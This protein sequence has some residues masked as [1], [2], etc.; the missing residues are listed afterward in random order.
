M[1]VVDFYEID[2]TYLQFRI[3]SKKRRK[4]EEE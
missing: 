4:K 2:I 3:L 1:L